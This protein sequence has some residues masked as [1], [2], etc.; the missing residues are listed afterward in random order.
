MLP[1]Y[2]YCNS[3]VYHDDAECTAT[4]VLWFCRSIC[5]DQRQSAAR[6]K[7][8]GE[9]N[10]LRRKQNNGLFV[11]CFKNGSFV[12]CSRWRLCTSCAAGGT[13]LWINNKIRIQIVLTCKLNSTSKEKEKEK[14]W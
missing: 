3:F 10:D 4:R 14:E 8:E 2:M 9:G 5:R 12:S 1:I 13:S 11:V 6:Y 7:N